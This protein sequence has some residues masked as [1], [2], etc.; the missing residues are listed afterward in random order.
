MGITSS[1]SRFSI[2]NT[3]ATFYHLSCTYKTNF[4]HLYCACNF[5]RKKNGSNG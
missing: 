4:L 3:F 5:S 1:N 2:S